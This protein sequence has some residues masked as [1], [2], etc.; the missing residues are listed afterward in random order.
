MLLNACGTHERLDR[1]TTQLVI[2]CWSAV[3]LLLARSKLDEGTQPTHH[4]GEVTPCC[5]FW[6]VRILDGEAV[7]NLKRT[8]L[9]QPNV[10]GMAPELSNGSS[11][12]VGRRNA[13]AARDAYTCCSNIVRLRMLH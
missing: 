12:S 5:L 3:L 11:R 10:P 2:C 13:I 1:Q 4:Q 6:T 7:R 8:K 9:L